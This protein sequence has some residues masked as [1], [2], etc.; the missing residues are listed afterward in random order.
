MLLYVVID[1][2]E[3]NS[4]KY[5]KHKQMR[6]TKPYFVKLNEFVVIFLRTNVSIMVLQNSSNL[7]D[8]RNKIMKH[9]SYHVL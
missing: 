8:K 9:D 4:Y 3:H 7:R 1:Y 5:R 2:C 6:I